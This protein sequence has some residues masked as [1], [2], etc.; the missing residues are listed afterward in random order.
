M[1]VSFHSIKLMINLLELIIT[2]QTYLTYQ[3]N[4]QNI[5]MGMKSFSVCKGMEHYRY[6]CK[7]M[8]H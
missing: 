2:N 7:K 1:T 4:L 5:F 8:L 6:M 3:N